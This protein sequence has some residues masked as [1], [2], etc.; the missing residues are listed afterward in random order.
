MFTI[1]RHA[2]CLAK[3]LTRALTQCAFDILNLQ[4]DLRIV[5]VLLFVDHDV[6]E[7]IGNAFLD[8]LLHSV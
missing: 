3:N 6:F 4:L 2:E 7:N 5:L 1:V 8:D